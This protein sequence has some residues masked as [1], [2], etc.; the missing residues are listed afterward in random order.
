MLCTPL[1]DLSRLGSEPYV[2]EPKLDGQRAQVHVTRG[3]AVHVYSQPR[4]VGDWGVASRLDLAYRHPRT[5][6]LIDNR[7]AVRV[8]RGDDFT[9]RTGAH[10]ELVCW[11][12]MPSGML[13]HPLFVRWL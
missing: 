10:A 5:S 9:A 11:G 1:R 13:R 8:P 4:R 7:Q 6:V 3:R 2:A 12:I